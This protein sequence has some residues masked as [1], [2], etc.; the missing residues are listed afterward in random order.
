MVLETT[1]NRKFKWAPTM[2]TILVRNSYKAMFS[3]TLM[4]PGLAWSGESTRGVPLCRYIHRWCDA[5][6]T[7]MELAECLDSTSSSLSN[8]IFSKSQMIERVVLLLQHFLY[9]FLFFWVGGCLDWHIHYHL[10]IWE[11]SSKFF[12]LAKRRVKMFTLVFLI[13][14]SFWSICFTVM[15][16]VGIVGHIAEAKTLAINEKS[17]GRR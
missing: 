2:D 13:L 9:F 14:M 16:I 1:N 15:M 6:T 10:L 4:N 11:D 8:S 17:I 3:I 7:L 12:S 5:V